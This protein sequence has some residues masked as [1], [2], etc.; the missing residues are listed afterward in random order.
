MPELPDVEHF[1][2]YIDR[3]SLRQNIEKVEILNKK[4]LGGAPITS[5]GKALKGIIFSD[6]HRH[7]KYLFL[8]TDNSASRTSRHY[9]RHSPVHP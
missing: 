2:R 8:K 4:V 6:T 3:T 7:G 1:R 9:P 5:I